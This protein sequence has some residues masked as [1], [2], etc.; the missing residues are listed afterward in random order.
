MIKIYQEEITTFINQYLTSLTAS[1][2]IVK[3][4]SYAIN[5]GGK[6]I[7]P[8]LLLSLLNDLGF[9]YHLGINAASAIEMIHTYSLVHDDLP[10]MDDDD[11]RRGVL[12]V[13][14]MFD[15][16]TAILVGDALLSEAF[17]VAINDELQPKQNLDILQKLSNYSGIKGMILGQEYDLAAENRSLSI[18]QL[19]LMHRHKTGKLLA[20]PLV[21]AAIIA[22]RY[23]LITTMEDIGI[24]LGLAFQI[25]DDVFDNTKTFAEMGKSQNSDSKK[26][27]FTYLSL[28]DIDHATQSCDRIFLIIEEKIKALNLVD[29]QLLDLINFIRFRPY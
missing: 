6:K 24:E 8:I 26:H 15:E 22:N 11:Y 29:G 27:K 1:E 21:C 18:Q 13:H 2:K 17:N 23:D 20:L 25:Q 5:N 7:R 12:T 10:A 4:M 16:A 9:D 14:K 28:M 3:G 19:D